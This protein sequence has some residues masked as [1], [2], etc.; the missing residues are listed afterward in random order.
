M[1]MWMAKILKLKWTLN[2]PE[3]FFL[4]LLLQTGETIRVFPLIAS[5]DLIAQAPILNMNQHN[6]YYGCCTCEIVVVH[7]D[8]VHI[9]PYEETVN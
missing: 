8:N 4:R 9:Y 6:G 1:N 7:K 5:F 3:V 2:D